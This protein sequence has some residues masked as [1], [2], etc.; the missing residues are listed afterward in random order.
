MLSLCQLV[1]TQCDRNRSINFKRACMTK[2][3]SAFRNG[4]CCLE[5]FIELWRCV[6][7]N[8]SKNSRKG[9]FMNLLI[10]HIGLLFI[11][12]LQ[13]QNNKT[14]DHIWQICHLT[15][16]LSYTDLPDS[17]ANQGIY[18]CMVCLELLYLTRHRFNLA[19]KVT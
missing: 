4:A 10:L 3:I 15:H 7:R 6:D 11:C 19:S 5:M 8:R 16:V 18:V 17:L 14:F 2:F 9:L 12:P 13:G 1:S